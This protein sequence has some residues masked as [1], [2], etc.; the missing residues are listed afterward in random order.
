VLLEQH[1]T[2]LG[3]RVGLRIV[4]CANDPL[5]VVDCQREDHRFAVDGVAKNGRGGLV[6]QLRECE[7]VLVRDAEAG[8]HHRG[9]ATR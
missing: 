9:E 7:H 8:Q 6:D 4:E 3:E 5:P 1:S 2:H